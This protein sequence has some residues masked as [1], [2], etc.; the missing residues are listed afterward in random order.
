MS[1]ELSATGGTSSAIF[2]QPQNRLDFS[3]AAVPTDPVP[4]PHTWALMLAGLG[5]LAWARR[6][7]SR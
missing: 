5:M 3:V 1:I 2:A 4:E 6:R 7:L